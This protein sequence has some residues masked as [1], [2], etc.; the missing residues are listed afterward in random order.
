MSLPLLSVRIQF[1]H[2][3]VTA[4]QRT[5]QIA[6]ALGFD[7]QQ[8]TRL[9]TAVSEIARNAFSYASGGKA[10]FFLEGSTAPQL[11]SIRISDEGAGI[12]NLEEI[13]A[14][15]YRVENR[16]GARNNRRS[17]PDGPLPYRLSA[18]QR[19]HR[20][21]S[22]MLPRRVPALMG[23][24]VPALI[25]RIS[26]LKPRD[27]LDEFREQN[28]ELLRTLDELRRR[29][30]ELVSLNRE[31]EDTNRGVVALYAELDEKADHLRRADEVNRV[32][33]PT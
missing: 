3:V 1:E 26:Q 13:L 16:H 17:A 33:F 24:A 14:G 9:A 19:H 30:E 10:D 2:D 4:R 12:S 25:D 18:R 15:K 32:S 27:I 22:K 11:F 6:E 8:Q 31:L 5:R 23:P 21:M 7:L 20:N 28:Q 29:Q